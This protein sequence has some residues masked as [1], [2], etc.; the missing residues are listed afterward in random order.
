MS[1]DRKQRPVGWL[2]GTI[3]LKICF[4]DRAIEIRESKDLIRA[5]I[6]PLSLLI[7]HVHHSIMRIRAKRYNG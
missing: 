1:L 3:C 5:V 6:E 2:R 7:D 4:E